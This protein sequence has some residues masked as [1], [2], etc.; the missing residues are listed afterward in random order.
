MT[1]NPANGKKF[2]G[3][4]LLV[5]MALYA[6]AALAEVAKVTITAR[7]PVADG[8]SF[9]ST[10]AYEK[11]AGTIEFAID[12]KNPRNQAIVDLDRTTLAADGKVHFTADLYVLQPVVPA[13]GNGA[14]LF[15]IANRGT[16]GLLSRFNRATASGDP[17][18]AADLGD[19]FLMRE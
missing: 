18:T 8:Q 1:A 3:R 15:E 16:K 10:G 14:L 4:L 7:S 17:V 12:P 9:G 2:P 11:L 19:G 6:S 13:R 5:A